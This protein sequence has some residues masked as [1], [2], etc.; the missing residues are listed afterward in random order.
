MQHFAS[1]TQPLFGACIDLN[2]L[3]HMHHV[4][5]MNTLSLSDHGW[6]G[7]S[8]LKEVGLEVFINLCSQPAVVI[9][10]PKLVSRY[11][12]GRFWVI[13]VKSITCSAVALRQHSSKPV[14]YSIR[15]YTLYI[16]VAAGVAVFI[17]CCCNPHMQCM[18][19]PCHCLWAS[20]CVSC[21]WWCTSTL[22]RRCACFCVF[23]VT[24]QTQM[25]GMCL[26]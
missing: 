5:F 13:T 14:I 26:K 1:I 25:V 24:L 9:F 10:A 4:H 7:R 21:V 19:S 12:G 23:S 3:Q 20:L 15:Y 22:S 6:S 17:V 16:S 8:S 11:Q 2:Y 18:I